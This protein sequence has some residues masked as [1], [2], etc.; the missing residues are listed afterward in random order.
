MIRCDRTTHRLT[1]SDWSCY[2]LENRDTLI[3]AGEYPVQLTVSARATA[4]TLWTPWP[5]KQLP[6]VVVPGRDGIRIHAANRESELAGCLAVGLEWDSG[7]LLSSR[8]ALLKLRLML[9]F[10]TTLEIV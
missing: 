4:G 10:P 6:L 8:M 5:G 3:P 9:T 2:F 1:V 7:R